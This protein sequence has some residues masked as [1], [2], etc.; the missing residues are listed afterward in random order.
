MIKVA[1][2]TGLAFYADDQDSMGFSAIVNVE[3]DEVQYWRDRPLYLKTIEP[4]IT[5]GIKMSEN[6]VDYAENSDVKRYYENI[7]KVLNWNEEYND[8]VDEILSDIQSKIIISNGEDP[9]IDYPDPGTNEKTIE[10][11]DDSGNIITTITTDL[12]TREANEIDGEEIPVS[13]IN[14]LPEDYSDDDQPQIED[15]T[16]I[17]SLPD[18]YIKDKLWLNTEEVRKGLDDVADATSNFTGNIENVIN[19]FDIPENGDVLAEAAYEAAS[20]QKVEQWYGIPLIALSSEQDDISDSYIL[21][22]DTKHDWTLHLLNGFD[23]STLGKELRIKGVQIQ[24]GS[25]FMAGVYANNNQ[26]TI[27][28]QLEG[29]EI[30]YQE[31]IFLSDAANLKV[32]NYGADAHGIKRLCG[33][34][35]EYLYFTDVPLFFPDPRGDIPAFPNTTSNDTYDF[36]EARVDNRYIYPRGNYRKPIELGKKAV[37]LSEEIKTVV[38]SE[39]IEDTTTNEV[40]R[41]AHKTYMTNFACSLELNEDFTIMWYQY[42]STYETDTVFFLSDIVYNNYISYDY[43]NMSLLIQFNGRRFI[44]DVV[45]PEMIWAQCCVRYIKEKGQLIFSFMD[46]NTEKYEE[47]S[48]GVGADLEFELN[49]MFGRYDTELG[50]WDNIGVE[51]VT[52]ISIEQEFLE[53]DE[54]KYLFSNHKKFLENYKIENISLI[55]DF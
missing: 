19:D 42:R 51:T 40:I 28:L 53:T 25:K 48:V 47:I 16:V 23:N 41:A 14:R 5:Q 17:T 43:E 38:L 52:F 39:N 2:P 15:Q 4:L 11:K 21:Q 46:F 32:F 7:N 45:F 22:I 24:P 35:Y 20:N 55:D 36:Y 12:N 29:E 3:L 6:A 54:L 30:I 31:S 44:E 9:D 10:I 26:V 37:L 33:N 18:I 1:S 49:S 50:F 27:Y 13:L 8:L 34:I